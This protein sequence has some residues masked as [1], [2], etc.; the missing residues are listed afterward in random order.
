VLTKKISFLHSLILV[1]TSRLDKLTS[2]SESNQFTQDEKVKIISAD[3]KNV[4]IIFYY[5][6]RIY[7]INFNNQVDK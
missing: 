1:K 5:V 2:S 6:R 3:T 4:T 7:H